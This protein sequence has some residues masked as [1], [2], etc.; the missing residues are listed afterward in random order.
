M[1]IVAIS[2]ALAD[3]VRD[4]IVPG[5]NALGY[6]PDAV[7]EPCFYVGEFEIDYDQAYAGGMDEARVTCRLLVARSD[8]RSG[9]ERLRAYLGRTGSSVKTALEDARGAPGELALG[10]LADDLHVPRVHGQ[11]LYQVGEVQYYGAE[12]VVRIIGS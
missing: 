5:L 8:D 6:T 3:A 10:G 2:D 1:D 11:R 4:P 7:P 9:Q 12:I